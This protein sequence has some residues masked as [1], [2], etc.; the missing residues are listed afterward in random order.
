MD[1]TKCPLGYECRTPNDCTRFGYGLDDTALKKVLNAGLTVDYTDVKPMLE[2]CSGPVKHGINENAQAAL[3][4]HPVLSAEGF[5]TAV[6]SAQRVG[7]T[8]DRL[9]QG[10][11]NIAYRN[12]N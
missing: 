6:E 8:L 12:N 1:L 3:D 7:K 9:Y 11:G 5:Q 2:L 10:I 4:S